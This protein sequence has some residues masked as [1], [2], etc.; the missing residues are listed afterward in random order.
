M[1]DAVPLQDWMT[2]AVEATLEM[3]GGTLGLEGTVIG[4]GA[5]ARQFPGAYIGLT[6]P[7]EALQVGV[8]AGMD[9][10]QTLAKSMLGMAPEDE[11][12]PAGDV[13]DAVGEIANIFAGG[14][15][16]R[17]LPRLG[18]VNLGLP[19]FINGYIEPTDRLAIQAVDIQLGPVVTSLLVIQGR[20]T[21]R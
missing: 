10:L 14:I 21:A 11:D 9:G 8:V 6:T 5:T 2:A 16:K 3:A 20:E 15:K 18:A 13:A 7:T 1:S 19:L 4:A 17:M 12:L